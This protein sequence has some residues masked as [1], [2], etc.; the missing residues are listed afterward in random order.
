MNLTTIGMLLLLLFL[1]YYLF[2]SV[3]LILI[4]NGVI[5]HPIKGKKERD[6][7]FL[8]RGIIG[9]SVTFPF[10]CFVVFFFIEVWT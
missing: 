6:K 10:F 1:M 4:G 3:K 7:S 8:I 5:L 2:L 9:V